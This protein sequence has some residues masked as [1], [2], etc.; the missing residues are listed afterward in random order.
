[1]VGK[2]VLARERVTYAPA[3][4]QEIDLVLLGISAGQV[5]RETCVSPARERYERDAGEMIC[6]LFR[7]PAVRLD[8]R[9]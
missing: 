2:R 1:M 3:T 9:R 5:S 7:W 4:L 6:A 8:L